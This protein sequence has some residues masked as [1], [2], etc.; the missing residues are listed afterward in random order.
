MF[1]G[2]K[3]LYRLDKGATPTAVVVANYSADG[4]AW[5]T[6]VEALGYDGFEYKDPTIIENWKNRSK[7]SSPGGTAPPGGSDPEGAA[8]TLYTGWLYL[9]RTT[10]V[11]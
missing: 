8:N 7:N 3:K 11:F 10:G 6:R 4:S 5:D 9:Y 2:N 1:N